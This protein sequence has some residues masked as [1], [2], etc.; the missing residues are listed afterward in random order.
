MMSSRVT[1]PKEEERA[2]VDGADQE[3]A[4]REGGNAD[5]DCPDLNCASL[6][7]TIVASMAH[8]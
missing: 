6:R 8:I 1:L 7:L 5:P 3:G 4:E 2:Y